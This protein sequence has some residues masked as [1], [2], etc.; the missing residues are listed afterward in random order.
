MVFDMLTFSEYVQAFS[1][2]SL[3]ERFVDMDSFFA[4]KTMKTMKILPQTKV[5]SKAHFLQLNEEAMSHPEWEGLILRQDA[6]YE[7]K[8]TKRMMKVKS[9]HDAEYKVLEVVSGP[10]RVIE[11][12]LEITET[13]LSNVNIEHKGFKVSVGSGWS[14]AERR[15]YHA[16]PDQ[17]IG[18]LI[19]VKYFE[20]TT[21]QNGNLSL[22]FPTLK[23][24]VGETRDV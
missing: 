12:G 7:G 15:Q 22:R 10:I 21:D 6:I 3:S 18:K 13:M 1:R 8:R 9:F 23:Y 14:L 17:L 19:C 4:G 20:E 5:T 11:N 16:H 24:V 2:R